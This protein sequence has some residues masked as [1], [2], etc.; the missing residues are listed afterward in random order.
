MA[1][2][3]IFDQELADKILDRISDGESLRKIC[4]EDDMPGQTTVY[5]WLRQDEEFRQQYASAREL[6]ADTLFDETLDIADDATNDW[7]VRYGKEDE[8][9][10]WK[11]NGEAIRRSQLRIDTRKWIAGQL[12]PKVYGPRVQQDHTHAVDEDLAEWL[13]R[14][15]S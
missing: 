11:E 4:C 10:G 6:Q 9:P 15:T 2:P 12:R 7:M 8:A 1:R 3:T 13:G 14:K 5:R